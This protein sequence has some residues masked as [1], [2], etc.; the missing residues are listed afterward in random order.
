M[1][2]VS[3]SEFG[4]ALS[5]AAADAV[6]RGGAVTVLVNGRRRR[7]LSGLLYA[8]DLVLTASHGVERE[9]DIQIVLPDG[10]DAS[11][12]LAGRDPGTDLALLR[13]ASPVQAAPARPAAQAARVGHLVAAVGRP[14]REGIQASLGMVT[15]V[16]GGLRTAGGGVLPR[17]LVTDAVPLPGFSGGPL[18]DLAGS[19]LGLNTSGLARGSSL[20]IPAEVAWQSAQHLAEHGHVRRGYLGIRSQVVE[21]PAQAQ[22]GQATGL[23]V[24]GIEPEGPAAGVLMVGDIITGMDGQPL[25]DHDD[26]LVRLAGDVVGKEAAIHV[27]RGGQPQVLKVRIG[28]KA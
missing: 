24:V 10:S 11:A 2:N 26:L 25:T 23:L 16:G 12:V 22:A 14:T 6:E 15:A 13:L 3:G 4:L 5:N 19:V 21:L 27:L 17:Y 9:E 7:P 1:T 18:V 28:E 8:A 20:V